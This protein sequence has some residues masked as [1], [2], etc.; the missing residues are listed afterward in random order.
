MTP[1]APLWFLLV[2]VL[3]LAVIAV[4]EIRAARRHVDTAREEHFFDGP[5]EDEL[6]ARR[7]R[8]ERQRDWDF[9]PKWDDAA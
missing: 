1:I 8:L 3:L 7:D 6:A 2:P 5:L 9:P 4:I